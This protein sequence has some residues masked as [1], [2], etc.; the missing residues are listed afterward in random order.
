MH[1]KSCIIYKICIISLFS[2]LISG[3]KTASS[4]KTGRAAE[5]EAR[6]HKSKQPDLPISN[7]IGQEVVYI[8]KGACKTGRCPQYTATFYSGGRLIY[9]GIANMQLLGKYEY[10]IPLKIVE[11]IMNEARHIRYNRGDDRYP[12]TEGEQLTVTRLFLDGVSKEITVEGSTTAPALLLKFQT[13]VNNEV[14]AI[15]DEQP[16][17]PVKE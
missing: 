15:V 4:G 9:N 16:A 6:S 11:N 7:D 5:L 2:I 17:K 10:I 3:C 12:G 13:S 1:R 8:S 14:M